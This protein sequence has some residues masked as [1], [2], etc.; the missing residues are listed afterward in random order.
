VTLVNVNFNNDNLA[1]ALYGR[2][3]LALSH[4]IDA[5]SVTSSIDFGSL[6]VTTY[7]EGNNH[8]SFSGPEAP[9]SLRPWPQQ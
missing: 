4:V 5:Y 9:Q 3:G 2:T 6:G 1:I 8:L 7:S